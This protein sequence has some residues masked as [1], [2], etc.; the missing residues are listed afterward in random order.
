[1]ESF[2]VLVTLDGRPLPAAARGD[3]VMLDETGRTYFLV[4]KPRLYNVVRS[5][6]ASTSELKLSANSPDFLLYTF[7]FGP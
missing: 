2:K 4:D 7:T 3:D 6:Q 5:P 1:M